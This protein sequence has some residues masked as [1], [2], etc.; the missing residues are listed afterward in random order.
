MKKKKKVQRLY[1]LVNLP[2][3]APDFL[4]QHGV[5]VNPLSHNQSAQHAR[6]EFQLSCG[7]IRLCL[8]FTTCFIENLCVVKLA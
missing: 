4:F 7:I 8:L 1:R 2:A 5:F 3:S 6:P